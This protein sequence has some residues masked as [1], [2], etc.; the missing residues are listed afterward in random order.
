MFQHWIFREPALAFGLP[1][2]V[3]AAI[4]LPLHIG[5]IGASFLEFS[6]YLVVAAVLFAIA[7]A[8]FQPTLYPRLLSVIPQSFLSL[9]A[10]AVPAALAFWL[11]S[12]AGPIDEALDEGV[13]ASQGAAESDTVEAESDDT[14]DMTPDCNAEL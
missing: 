1:V 7:D 14:F 10:L 13:C 2:Y 8:L 4:L 11:G 6:G 5:W 3:F 12:I 9:L